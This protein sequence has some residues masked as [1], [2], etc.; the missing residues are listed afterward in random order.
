MKVLEGN[1][2]KMSKW[3]NEQNITDTEGKTFKNES[4]VDEAKTEIVNCKL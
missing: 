4:S 2:F 1:K 3:V